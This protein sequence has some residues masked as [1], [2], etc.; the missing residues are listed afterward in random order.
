[1]ATSGA[2][3]NAT[4]PTKT[5]LARRGNAVEEKNGAKATIPLTLTR[6]SVMA[7]RKLAQS[8]IPILSFLTVF[9]RAR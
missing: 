7:L 4:A 9:V 6:A 2:S 1:V 5:A 3:K 8:C